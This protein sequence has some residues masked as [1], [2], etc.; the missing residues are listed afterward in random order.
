MH[1]YILDRTVHFDSAIQKYLVQ[2]PNC[3]QIVLLGSGMD[4]RAYRL[5]LHTDMAVFEIDYPDT[6]DYKTNVLKVTS[7]FPSSLSSNLSFADDAPSC[8]RIVV[9]ADMTKDDWPALLTSLDHDN[10][11]AQ[12]SVVFD[13]TQP[14]LWLAEG[15]L[16]YIPEAAVE[17]YLSRID[18]LS[19]ESS[20]FIFDGLKSRE[21]LSAF[22]GKTSF[23]FM[24]SLASDALTV[25]SKLGWQVS[26]AVDQPD[27]NMTFYK[28]SK[29]EQK[30]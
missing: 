11:D 3:Q 5:G 21:R 9:K 15:F 28:M 12:S 10:S 24:A 7:I 30:D 19:A 20:A 18:A 29:G 8:R 26:D 23:D 17:P 2:H 22:T 25:F 16:M 6:H 1:N 14:T 13:R 4:T 27:A